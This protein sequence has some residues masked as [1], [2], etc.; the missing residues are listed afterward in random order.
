[1][2]A[3]LI[4]QGHEVIAG[5]MGMFCIL[6]SVVVKCKSPISVYFRFVNFNICKLSSIKNIFKKRFLGGDHFFPLL[7]QLRM[8][9]SYSYRLCI[10]DSP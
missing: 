8:S 5:V 9:V 1:M 4:G 2:G 3:V 10:S 7:P 6:I